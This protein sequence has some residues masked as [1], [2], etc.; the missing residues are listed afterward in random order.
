MSVSHALWPF[1]LLFT[2]AGAFIGIV[3][4]RQVLQARRLLR[5]G[6]VAPGTVKRLERTQIASRLGQ[7]RHDQELRND[8]VLPGR[9]LDNGGRAHHGESGAH[10][11]AGGP[12]TFRRVTR[13]DPP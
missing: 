11:L 13:R 4:A 2:P 8:G 10:R 5:C 6:S 1:A 9:L 3:A 7:Q 12:S